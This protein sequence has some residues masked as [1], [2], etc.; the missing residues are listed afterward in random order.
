M[1]VQNWTHSSEQNSNHS[2][3]RLQMT[4]EINQLLLWLT[5]WA[6]FSLQS[7]I[8]RQSSVS[9]KMGAEF[10]IT[11]IYFWNCLFT[12]DY[13][14]FNVHTVILH[15]R[16]KQRTDQRVLVCTY[17]QI[18]SPKKTGFSPIKSTSQTF[19]DFCLPLFYATFQCGPYNIFKKTLN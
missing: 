17:T 3:K 4:A 15:S 2:E 16:S 11:H 18:F 14:F 12:F 19:F 5:L 9:L 6:E 7:W 1:Y 10:F 13:F 8:V